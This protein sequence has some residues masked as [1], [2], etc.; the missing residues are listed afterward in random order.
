MREI[1]NSIPEKSL[2]AKYTHKA[3]IRKCFLIFLEKITYFLENDY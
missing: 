1:Q 2:L 3:G